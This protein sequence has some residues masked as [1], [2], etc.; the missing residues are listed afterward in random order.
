VVE[1]RP[2]VNLPG[3]GAF[4]PAGFAQRLA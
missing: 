1:S 3:H 4:T 2:R